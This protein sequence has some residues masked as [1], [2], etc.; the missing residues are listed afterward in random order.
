LWTAATAGNLACMSAARSCTILVVEDDVAIQDAVAGAL[1]LRGFVLLIASDGR[2]ALELARA[3]PAAP[4][5]IL[6]D[7]MMPVMS[8]GE[9]LRER[10][11][12]ATL[13]TV[14]V[15]VF[16]AVR[17]A[18]DI[19]DGQVAAILTKPV[20]MRMLVDVV[21]RL[22]GL[23]RERPDTT[24]PADAGARTVLLRRPRG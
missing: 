3:A 11:L 7:W 19:D 2:E 24:P 22:C 18:L 5:L 16:T 15:V 8:G 13:R 23:P 6:L 10:A 4:S 21:D 9:F 12:D 14:P 17:R 1:Q 20:R